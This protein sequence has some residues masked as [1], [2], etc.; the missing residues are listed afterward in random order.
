MLEIIFRPCGLLRKDWGEPVGHA[1]DISAETIEASGVLWQHIQIGRLSLE[2]KAAILIYQGMRLNDLL[3]P[4]ELQGTR[5]GSFDFLLR[6]RYW[7]PELTPPTILD[8]EL[9]KFVNIPMGLQQRQVLDIILR[10]HLGKSATQDVH[11]RTNGRKAIPA[12]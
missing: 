10:H 4:T 11:S 12:T 8:L 5:L 9:I 3:L 6:Y 2:R 1:A 7:G